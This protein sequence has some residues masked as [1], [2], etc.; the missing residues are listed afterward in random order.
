MNNIGIAF[1]FFALINAAPV[2]ASIHTSKFIVEK[3]EVDP[4]NLKIRNC[5]VNRE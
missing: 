2:A 3:C 4:S 1:L 5:V